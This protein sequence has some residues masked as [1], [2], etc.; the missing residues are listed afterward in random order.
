MNQTPAGKLYVVG[1]P[2]G[3]L[4]DITPRAK[5]TLASVDTIACENRDRHVRLLNHLGIKKHL[6]EYSPAN[7]KNSAKGIVKLLLEGKNI[8]LVSDAGMPG[9]SDPG[10]YVVEEARNN[11]VTVI[12]I[13]GVSALTTLLA[14]S[15]FSSSRVVF[16]GFLS[17][18]PGKIAKELRLYKDLDAVLVLF[19]SSYQLKKLLEGLNKVF[20]NVE[21]VIGREMTKLNEEY[22]RG[23]VEG[24]LGNLPEDRGEFTLAVRQT[25]KTNSLETN[26]LE[27][28]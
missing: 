4:S 16:L 25:V 21:I 13:P 12:P 10:R 6:I 27:N 7:E 11:G 23:T 26:E 9:V 20:G 8:A 2:I 24:F 19:V 1:T 28:E 15:G 5:E 14:V 18:S 17:K 22:L 3:N